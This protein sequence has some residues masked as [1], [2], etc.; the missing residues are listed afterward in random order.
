MSDFSDDVSIIQQ[1]HSAKIVLAEGGFTTGQ[2]LQSLNGAVKALFEERQLQRR[3]ER[4]YDDITENIAHVQSAENNYN[5]V[6]SKFLL[7]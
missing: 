6:T 1:S 3:L 2:F 7:L 5:S 4:I